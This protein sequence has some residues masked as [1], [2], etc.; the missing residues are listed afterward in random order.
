MLSYQHA[1]HAGNYADVLKHLALSISIECLRQSNRP[2]LYIDT[3]AGSGSYELEYGETNTNK[4]KRDIN[5]LNFTSIPDAI[6]PY[7][8]TVKS[9]LKENRYP[10]SPLIAASLLRD[11]DQLQ[12][13]ELHS[14]EYALLK[15]VLQKDQRIKVHHSDGYQVFQDLLPIR[16]QQLL[17][18]IDPP[19]EKHQDYTQVV[20]TLVTGAKIM[21]KAH[22]LIW[23]PVIH[24]SLINKMLHEF[25]QIG[26]SNIWRYELGISEDTNDNKM[27]A[28]G[29]VAVNCHL[30]LHLRMKELLPVVKQQL[31]PSGFYLIKNL[32]TS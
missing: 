20:E 4:L 1:A 21:S 13:F 17:I 2:I 9:F 23:Y 18:L 3:H 31:A 12:L 10:G 24:R 7:R 29:I 28:S 5:R 30:K 16:N 19:Y 11:Q 6:E 22:Y 14:N 8:N 15:Q 25:S 32:L 27:T 26:F